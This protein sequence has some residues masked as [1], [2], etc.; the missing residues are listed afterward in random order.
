MDSEEGINESKSNLE[1]F[2]SAQHHHL[3]PSHSF[4]WLN[5]FQK[6][7]R[8]VRASMKTETP[9]LQRLPTGKLRNDE[10]EQGAPFLSV[11]YCVSYPL[12]FSST[13]HRSE[14]KRLEFVRHEFELCLMI[15]N[16]Q[17]A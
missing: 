13:S 16:P 12:A 1:S 17:L 10:E 2:D 15:V 6:C 7:N 11:S 5:P 8:M 14:S 3:C 9:L 4:C